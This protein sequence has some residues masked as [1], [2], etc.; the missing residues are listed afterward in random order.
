MS[1][2]VGPARVLVA[3]EV[4]GIR[5]AV[6]HLLEG[7]GYEV[8]PVADGAAAMAALGVDVDGLVIDVALPGVLAYEVV[9]EARRR[10]LPIKIVLI[11]SI[12]NRT[13]YKRRPTSLYGADD[14]IEQHHIPDALLGKLAT[15][16]GPDGGSGRKQ[17]E[18]I[19]PHTPT[20]EG[21]AI[22]LAGEARLRNPSA[23]PLSSGGVGPG[24][25]AVERAV[26]LAR[27]I[28]AD[29]ALYNGDALEAAARAQDL[30]ELDARLR[31][32]LEEGRLLFDLRIPAAVRRT[33]DFIGEAVREL[34][35]NR[36]KA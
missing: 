5:A 19:A 24:D 15:L 29:I 1:N 2:S 26:R 36:G 6:R 22:Q 21:M 16:L 30:T 4:E 28:V 10:D 7:E 14:Y 27:L 25:R 13:G 31:L 18:A 23:E 3:H 11:A 34:V 20:P 9:A 17:V 35:D 12:Y 33:R 8:I 32:D